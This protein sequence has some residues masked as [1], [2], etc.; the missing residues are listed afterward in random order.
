MLVPFC[1]E[2]FVL[3]EKELLKL[4]AHRFP[5]EKQ[6][7]RGPQKHSYLR[8]ALSRLFKPS[9]GPSKP[10]ELSLEF[11]LVNDE[12]DCLSRDDWHRLYA[13]RKF[14]FM[15]DRALRARV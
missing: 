4:S 10:A 8:K 7:I 14:G 6:N 5:K 9:L 15:H 11:E 13:Q 3:V 1:D 12:P 2:D